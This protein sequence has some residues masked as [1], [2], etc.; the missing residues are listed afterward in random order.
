[1]S[2]P[3]LVSP[4]LDGFQLNETISCRSGAICRAVTEQQSGHRSVLKIVSIPA[5]DSQMDALLMTGAFTNR[6]DANSYFKEQARSMLNE[7]KMLRHMTTLGGFTDFDSVQVIPADNGCGYDIYMLSPMRESMQQ[8]LQKED[9][10]HLEVLNLGLDLCAAL[11]MCRHTGYIYTNLKP[12]NV[13][14]NG[15]HYRIGDLGFLPLSGVNRVPIPERYRSIYTAPELLD[16]SRPMN[17]TADVY[18]LGLILYQ[19]YNGG[20]LPGQKDIVGML[21]A[22]PIYADYEMA[23]IILRACAPDPSIRWKDP[24]QMG[25]ALTRYLQKNGMRN[26][27]IVP[28]IL[29][30]LAQRN[31][32]AVEEFL[33]EYPDE[34]TQELEV[35]EETPRSMPTRYA[36]RIK[37]SRPVRRKRKAPVRKL[38]KGAIVIGVLAVLL[39]IEL[40]IGIL[41]LS[42]SKEIDITSFSA[43]ADGTSVT[44][45]LSYDGKAPDQWIITYSYGAESKQSQTFSGSQITITD[46][47]PGE[48]YTFTLTSSNGQTLTGL[49][50]I[51]CRLPE[52]NE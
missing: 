1:M 27:P 14:R 45:F 31:L 12:G 41:V 23:Q 5:S 32:P 16:G 33:P 48:E 24:E 44:L 47:S 10:T 20:K 18:A 17:E 11:T 37:S 15:Q 50:Q 21:Y 2:T 7:V 4:I 25:R 28:P 22:P 26:S 49:T 9:L 43:Q 51:T 19:A 34:D 6:A 46:L 39:V 42:R 13:F 40:I 52:N 29:Q 30:E 35:P 38:S 3:R 8:M 36:S